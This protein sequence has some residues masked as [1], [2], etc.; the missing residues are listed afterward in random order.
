M[1][2]L[3]LFLGFVLLVT[4]LTYGSWRFQRWFHYK[5]AYSSQVT[6]Q[7]QPIVDR[8]TALEKRV[9]ELENKK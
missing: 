9:F 3:L 7:V 4:A 1:K 8:V 6:E 5:M 2:N